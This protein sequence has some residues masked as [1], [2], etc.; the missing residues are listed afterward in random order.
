MFKMHALLYIKSSA[1]SANSKP[2]TRRR[3]RWEESC[4]L[5]A[6]AASEKVMFAVDYSGI[7][8]S[9]KVLIKNKACTECVRLRCS[10]DFILGKKC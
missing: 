1:S 7:L 8:D 9:G 4:T 5:P 10:V 6:A 3:R 2:T